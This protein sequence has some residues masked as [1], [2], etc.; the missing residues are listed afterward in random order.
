MEEWDEII[1]V[2]NEEPIIIEHRNFSQDVIDLVD[3]LLVEEE[4]SDD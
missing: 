3:Q 4:K 1:E 2:P